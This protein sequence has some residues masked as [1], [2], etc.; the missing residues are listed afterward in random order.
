MSAIFK[1]SFIL[2]QTSVMKGNHQVKEANFIITQLLGAL[3]LVVNS[4]TFQ[5]TPW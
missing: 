5:Y 1:T 3:A 2:Y 4:P